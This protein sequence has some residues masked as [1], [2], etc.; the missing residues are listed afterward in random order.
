MINTI[1]KF[2]NLYGI[3]FFLIPIPIFPLSLESGIPAPNTYMAD[4][5]ERLEEFKPG[6]PP[7]IIVFHGHSVPSGYFT[8]G[9]VQPY[10]SYPY[11][12][13]KTLGENFP[14]AAIQIITTSIGGENAER[15]ATRFADDVLKRRADVIFIDYSLNDRAIG[16]ERAEA[17][18]RSMIEAAL[19]TETK[20]ILMTPTPDTRES[21][22]D[23]DTPLAL[24]AA[25]VRN[26]ATEYEVGSVDSYAAFY[27]YLNS[28]TSV[29]LLDLMAQNNHPNEF[30]H[31]IVADKIAE[32]FPP[33]IFE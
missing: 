29:R 15:G 2:L 28:S 31:K 13:W 11:L 8:G 17:A 26:L 16:L 10:Q 24:H 6:D 30:G 19:D 21:L 3:G 1:K 33:D 4:A 22:D 20:I 14:A 25:Q 12:F 7:M 5:I 27:D 32:W 23:P 9:R 18:W